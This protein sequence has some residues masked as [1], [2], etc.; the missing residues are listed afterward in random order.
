MRQWPGKDAVQALAAWWM[1]A[2]L[3]EEH[4]YTESELYAVIASMCAARDATPNPRPLLAP[5]ARPC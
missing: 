4:P 2:T 5:R 3:V 1:A